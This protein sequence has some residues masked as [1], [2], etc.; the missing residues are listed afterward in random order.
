MR[1]AVFVAIVATSFRMGQI[2]FMAAPAQLDA[3]FYLLI[4]ILLL[5]L[6]YRTFLAR[7]IMIRWLENDTSLVGRHVLSFD[8]N[9]IRET[10]TRG[11]LL[12]H[13]SAVTAIDN[14]R[15]GIFIALGATSFFF[16]PR[17]AFPGATR[18]TRSNRAAFAT[19][20]LTNL[21]NP[22]VGVFYVSFL[23]QFV[24]QGTPVAPYILLYWP[25]CVT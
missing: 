1:N 6:A 13:W 11:E 20:T 23:P 7:Q 21:L 17:R 22:K 9:G 25:K 14:A 18:S 5:W 4:G 12:G 15:P 2:L 24:P 16:I 3:F 10:S 19:G 8:V